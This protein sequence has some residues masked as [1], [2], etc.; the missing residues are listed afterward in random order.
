MGVQ[1]R[2]AR[3]KKELRQEILDAARDLFVREGFE[4]VSMRKIAEKIEYSPTTIYLYF[5]DKSDLL[6]CII[7]ETFARLVRK[8]TLLEQTVADPVERLEKGLRSYVE[9]GLKHPNHYKVTFMMPE[10]PVT[11]PELCP[12]SREMGQK[13]FANLRNMLAECVEKKLLEIDDLEA[14]AQAA[15][16]MVHGLTSLMIAKPHYKWAERN[17]LIDT[18]LGTLMRGLTAKSPVAV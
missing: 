9:F 15:W 18:L 1:E 6:D 12:R 2:R 4:N 17:H 11:D 3:E 10:P 14:T 8:Q 13:A 5:R 16:A 7:E